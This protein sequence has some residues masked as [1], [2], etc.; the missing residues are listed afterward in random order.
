[1]VRLI[2]R[3][4]GGAEMIVY[5]A[6]KQSKRDETLS[7]LRGIADDL[8]FYEMRK[9]VERDATLKMILLLPEPIL[10]QALAVGKALQVCAAHRHSSPEDQAEG[11][12]K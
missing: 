8:S 12:H 2:V 3:E 9:I 11:Y 10:D 6:R 5:E 7:A 1:M 4:R